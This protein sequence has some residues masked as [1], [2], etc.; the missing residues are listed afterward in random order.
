MALRPMVDTT[1]RPVKLSA[2]NMDNVYEAVTKYRVLSNVNT[3]ALVQCTPE[4]GLYCGLI[5]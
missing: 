3:A 4:T 1:G 5:K 2:K